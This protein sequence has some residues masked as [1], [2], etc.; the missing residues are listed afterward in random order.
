MDQFSD[1]A[2]KGLDFLKSRAKETVESQ[3]LSSQIRQLEGKRDS[4]LL[5]LGHRVFVM[6][7]MDRFEPEPLQPRIDEIRQLNRELES[8]QDEAKRLK[9]Q[10]RKSVEEVIPGRSDEP[11]ESES[12]VT[13]TP[14]PSPTPAPAP[15]PAPV[16]QHL[17]AEEAEAALAQAGKASKTTV[18]EEEEVP[19]TTLLTEDDSPAGGKTRHLAEE[20]AEE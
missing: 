1:K 14:A 10:F 20:N 13:P 16:T 6:F 5:D 12:P 7:E 11:T 2:R 4:C 19:E 3:K 15:K 8:K 18:L 9:E 17:P